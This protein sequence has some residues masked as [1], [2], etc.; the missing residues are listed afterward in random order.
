VSVIG[1]FIG[2][3][4]SP[5]FQNVI[6]NYPGI[7]PYR[8]QQLSEELGVTKKTLRNFLKITENKQV[9]LDDLDKTLRKIAKHYKDLMTKV[10]T[11]N[12]EDPEVA[13]LIEQV[14]QALDNGEFDQT[15]QLFNQASELDIEA[16]KQAQE[17]AKKRLVSA[18]ES[19]AANGKLKMTQLTYQQ[20]GEYYERAA[21]L[22]P[23]GNDKTLAYYLNWA[24]YAFKDAALY[25]KAKP[26]YEKALAIREKVFGQEHPD[27]A[28]SFNNLA[29]LYKN[30]G[31]YDKAKLSSCLKGL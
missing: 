25:D 11:L 19:L 27:V 16:A 10:A 13:K 3:F 29:E 20:A 26:L 8:F 9:S 2:I 7:S 12:S 5:Y 22:L 21:K 14:K 4:H 28:T 15:E 17:I 31:N 24:G 18:A 1:L 30:Q 6:I 23:A